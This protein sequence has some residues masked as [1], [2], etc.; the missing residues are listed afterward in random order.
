MRQVSDFLGIQYADRMIKDL[1]PGARNA[2]TDEEIDPGM[3]AART[4][5][6]PWAQEIASDLDVCGY[7]E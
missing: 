3:L 6:E 2:L 4:A 1:L 5:D 7:L